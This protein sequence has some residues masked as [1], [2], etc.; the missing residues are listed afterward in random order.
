MRNPTT[1]TTTTRA[2]NATSQASSAIAAG[3]AAGSTATSATRGF[4]V[5]G[6]GRQLAACDTQAQRRARRGISRIAND[7]VVAAAAHDRVT[8]I[9][10]GLRAQYP[11]GRGGG[12]DSGSVAGDESRK[13]RDEARRRLLLCPARLDDPAPDNPRGPV[14]QDA[15]TLARS[16]QLSLR[17]KPFEGPPLRLHSPARFA[18]CASGAGFE[19]ACGATQRG[20][21]L[22]PIRNDD[23]RRRGWRRSADV[24]REVGQCDV[25]LVTDAAH[26]PAR[27]GRPPRERRARR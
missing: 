9:E 13:D 8:A 20:R 16:G 27:C 12:L 4:R 14:E 15:G 6:R 25:D 23:L 17:P 21:E 22:R 18:G 10:R 3:A 7:A 24:G 11:E 2:T 19:P 5:A 1:S 26:R